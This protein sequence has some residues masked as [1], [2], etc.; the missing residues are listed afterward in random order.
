VTQAAQAARWV[1]HA[2][3]DSPEVGTESTT[4]V[5]AEPANPEEEGSQHYVCE[6]IGFRILWRALVS[7]KVPVEG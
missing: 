5:E 4:A 1:R 6:I 7:L 3:G 2:G